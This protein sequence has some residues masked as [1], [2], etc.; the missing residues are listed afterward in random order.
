MAEAGEGG[1]LMP[2]GTTSSLYLFPG[3]LQNLAPWCPAPLASMGVRRARP[4]HGEQPGPA[5]ATSS[6]HPASSWG[7][8]ATPC[9]RGDTWSGKKRGQP[10]REWSAAEQ[11]PE[12]EEGGILRPPPS[13]AP[14]IA[15]PAQPAPAPQGRTPQATGGAPGGGSPEE[16]KDSKDEDE[17]ESDEQFRKRLEERIKKG[18]RWSKR[19]DEK[20]MRDVEPW[21]NEA[22]V[23]LHLLTAATAGQM[24]QQRALL[25]AW[26]MAKMH[27][28][29]VE[30]LAPLR[31]VYDPPGPPGP[32]GEQAP[33]TYTVQHVPF[34]SSDVCNWRNQ[35]PSFEENP[36]KIIKLFEGIFKTY[37][38]TYDDVQYL[39]DSL[40]TTEETRRVHA[41]ARKHLR[42]NG[43]GDD[44]LDQTYPSTTPNWNYQEV[45]GQNAL[46]TYRQHVLT[47][48]RRA[49]RKPTNLMK[50]REVVQGNDEAPGA[51]LERL[52]EAYRQYTPVDPDDVANAPIIKAAFVAQ[53]AP[54]IRRKVQKHDG[55]MGHPL[56]WMLEIAQN[57]YNQREEEA[58]KKKEKYQ[59]KKLMALQAGTP[60]RGGTQGG[61]RARLG[62][63]QC[64]ICK[65]DGHWKRECPQ[66]NSKGRGQGRGNSMNPAA[67]PWVPGRGRG[68]REPT[69][70]MK[71]G[72]RTFSFL[73]DTGAAHSVLPTAI[74]KP[75]QQAITIVGATGEAQ[76]A[77]FLQPVTCRL[78]GHTVQHKF[79]YIPE[80]PIPLLGRDMLTKL[81]AQIAFSP[82]GKIVMNTGPVG[83]LSLEVP[84]REH[85]RLMMVKEEEGQ[86]PEIILQGTNPCVLA[87]G[88][89]PGMARNIPPIIVKPKPF[90]NPVAVNQYPIPRVAAEGVWVHLE[91]LLRHGIL[92]QCQS[93]WNTPLL[94]VKKEDGG[95]RPVQDLRLV[96]Q[97]VET[98]HPNVPNP[99]TLLS[100]IPPI[101]QYFTVLDLKDAFFCCRL[102]E[103]SQPLFAFQ[104]TDPGT[105][106]KVQYT[107][108]RLPQGFKNSPTLF[109]V[110]LASD[111]A[112]FPTNPTRVLLQYV[113]DLL[114]ACSDEDTCLKAT[115]EL[116]NHLAEAGY[117]VSKKKAQICQPTVKYLGFDISHRQRKLRDERKQAILQI[118]EP[119]NRRELRGFLGS[120]GFCRI[121]IPNYSSIAR[122]LHESTRGTEKDP[123]VW[124]PEQQQAF[125]DL[126]AALQQAPALGIPN[127]EK[128]F[129]L[130]TDEDQGIAKGVL[131]QRLGSWQQP[132]AYLSERLTPTEQGLPPCMRAVV[133][134]ATLLEK[135]DKFTFGQDTICVTPH[136]VPALL[137]MKGTYFL[138]QAK[139]RKCQVLLLN[140]R[141]K[142]QVTAA[143]NP[144]TL[145]PVG[146]GEEP[147]HDCVEVMDEVYSSR[148][149][150]K[151]K[152]NP[153]WST[154]FVDGSSFVENGQRKAGYAVVALE[155]QVIEAKPLSPG[156]SA[157]LAE[158]TALTRAL[159]LAEGKKINIYTDSKYAFL[160]L[161]AHGA[162]WKERGLLTSKGSLVAHP[163]ALLDLLDAVWKPEAV[164]VVHCYGHKTGP[165]EEARGNRLADKV[166]KEAARESPPAPFIGALV[167]EALLDTAAKPRYSDAEKA[168]AKEE[169]LQASTEGWYLTPDDRI[170]VPT[171][172]SRQIVQRWTQA[173]T[174]CV[175]TEPLH[176]FEPG[177]EVWIKDWAQAPLQPCW[178]GPHTVLI[179]TPT[180]VKVAGI[181]PW[182][183]HTRVKKV[184]PNW[185]AT[186]NP[187]YPLKLTISRKAP[188]DRPADTTPD[189]GK[190]PFC[191]RT[192]NYVNTT[193]AWNHSAP[194]AKA[195]REVQAL[196]N[197]YEAAYRGVCNK[198]YTA[199]H[200]SSLV[201]R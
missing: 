150:L 49:S 174:P 22:D 12:E 178:K 149:D 51:Y 27:E 84:L 163:Q 155:D 46:N 184:L 3:A 66:A 179:S 134:V 62:R 118:L 181:T 13:Y 31:R 117:R 201:Q 176:Q 172:L 67:E 61:G 60:T 127:P 200:L 69:V 107:W 146:E 197:D 112:N 99:Y 41:E 23:S 195:P 56:E 8:I 145:L 65:Q 24:K 123:F 36:A 52:K 182:V 50:V 97:A 161:H 33:R 68:S 120:A 14:P 125:Q 106:T 191:N 76:K 165:G 189:A 45:G 30:K 162:L 88:N 139:M 119:K 144:A 94:P 169:G 159:C 25:N 137:D 98:L 15:P 91:R 147:T 16:H 53:A 57:T 143:L 164:A 109:G 72:N 73:I 138:S 70:K 198:W 17:D 1:E 35:N 48:M 82:N 71:T 87:E 186:P 86:I 151:D 54:D 64:A 140:P 74:S 89:P 168:S 96:N 183:H 148:P 126:K 173:R 132:V 116:L 136:A 185:T 28:A 108:T 83:V 122:P 100:L 79:L 177:D 104:W 38:P 43:V 10:A 44:N 199:L 188:D 9:L 59:A 171:S 135:A 196:C 157:Q 152:A 110:A 141:L 90:A 156:T 77:P 37:N 124:G 194:C 34:T 167:P 47:G 20:L 192:Y 32:N 187:D 102:A 101:A 92:R 81:Q 2:G 133:A 63:N 5:S 142:F 166:A 129:T 26:E 85:W 40:L 58:Q 131:C 170:W 55:F 160:T 111:L 153:H 121:W 175:L 190:Y 180:A 128:P 103:E 29:K 130:Y 115:T 11:D 93:Q 95:Y 105:G 154:W 19:D 193:A 4:D 75:T 113:D 80:C 6:A 18:N 21:R 114:L 78:G 42:E 7:E 158:I 39:L